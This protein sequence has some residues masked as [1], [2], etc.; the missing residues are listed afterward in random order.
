MA[1]A[2]SRWRNSGGFVPVGVFLLTTAVPAADVFVDAKVRTAVETTGR[3]RIFVD[4]ASSGTL[5][6]IREVQA[7]AVENLPGFGCSVI[8]RYKH[9][10]V[11]ALDV[12]RVDVV[13]SISEVRGVRRIYIDEGGTGALLESRELIGMDAVE[14][15]GLTGEGTVFPLGAVAATVLEAACV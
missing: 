5:G 3:A 6:D 1:C 2:R 9:S 8:H 10:P 4:L 13:E 7:S 14:G 15:L 12:T 11:L